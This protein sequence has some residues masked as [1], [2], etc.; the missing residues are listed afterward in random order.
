MPK[1]FV[2]KNTITINTDPS[3]AWNA[4]T[5]PE[6]TKKYMYNSEVISDWNPG[7][8]I[9]WRDAATGKI[10]VKGII[11]DIEPG[12]YLRTKDLSIDAGL[13]DIESNYSRVTY[14]LKEDNKKTLLSVTEDSFNGDERRF[15][16]SKNFWKIVLKQMKELLEK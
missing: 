14:K 8:S 10:H 15:K 7:S 2:V 5:N 6:L 3:K 12:R 1:N 11:L 16:D 13:P 4:I 9:T